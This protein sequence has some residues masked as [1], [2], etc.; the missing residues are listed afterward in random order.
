MKSFVTGLII[1]ALVCGA[2]V[3][4]FHGEPEAEKPA[5]E[6]KTKDHVEHSKD[7]AVSV[8]LEE[9]ER[10]QMGLRTQPVAKAACQPEIKAFGR[11]LNATDLPLLQ[12]EITVAEVGLKG[13][14]AAF[15]RLK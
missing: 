1:G 15:D 8:K 5:P 13:S 2:A 3:W 4:R 14:K 9:K 10:Q 11:V 6:E 12:A 7:G